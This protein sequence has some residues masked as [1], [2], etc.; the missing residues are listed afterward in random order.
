MIKPPRS[1]LE[2][3]VPIGRNQMGD[4]VRCETGFSTARLVLM[5][6]KGHV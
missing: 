5:N 1:D 6:N 4:F 2:R 3:D